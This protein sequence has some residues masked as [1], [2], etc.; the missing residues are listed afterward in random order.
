MS[1]Q[2]DKPQGK[3]FTGRH[4]LM[5]MLCFFGVIILVNLTM[6]VLASKSWTGLI[7]K[8]GYVASQNFNKNQKAQEQFLA[9]GWR[10][11]LDYKNGHLTL[12]LFKQEDAI[13]DCIVSGLLNR[14]VHE[15]SNQRLKFKHLYEGVYEVNSP[16]EVGRWNLEVQALCNNKG[17]SLPFIQH[18]K[19]IVPASQNVQ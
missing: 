11:Q 19:F 5:I 15:N 9:E 18:Y 17:T 16:L 10:S 7:V 8:N 6:A 2:M 3:V 12:T 13:K 14:P 1:D 4:M